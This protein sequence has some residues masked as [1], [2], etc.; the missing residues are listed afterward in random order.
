M[1]RFRVGFTLIELIAVMAIM[2]LLA[3]VAVTAVG[4]TMD[5]YRLSRAAETVE[6][7]D[8]RVRREARQTRRP[9]TAWID[10]RRNRLIVRGPDDRVSASF[11]LPGAVELAEFRIK[12]PGRATRAA[13]GSIRFDV[14]GSGRSPTYA[15]RMKLGKQE[16]WLVVLG[17]SGQV[18]PVKEKEAVDDLLSL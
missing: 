14:A 9:H 17:F 6:M 11:G 4:G 18:V 8:A 15:M 12:E 16:R 10:R 3:S 1:Y 2:G 7:F 5:R 13:H